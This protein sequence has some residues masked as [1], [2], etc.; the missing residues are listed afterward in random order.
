MPSNKTYLQD[1]IPRFTINKIFVESRNI[2]IQCSMRRPPSFDF[3]SWNGIGSINLIKYLDFHIIAVKGEQIELERNLFYAQNRVSFLGSSQGSTTDWEDSLKT[4]LHGINGHAKINILEVL[5]GDYLGR[6]PLTATEIPNNLG[7]DAASDHNISFQLSIECIEEITDAMPGLDLFAFCQLDLKS[8]NDDFDMQ[9]FV[10]SLTKIGGPLV[11]EKALISKEGTLVVPK[12]RKAFALVTGEFYSGPA[13]YH[14]PVEGAPGY[15]GWMTGPSTGDMDGRQR[16]NMREIQ[17]TK[18]SSNIF[19]E[20]SIN[21]EYDGYFAES[22]FFG[23]P[24][25]FAAPYGNLTLG[26]DLLRS[27]LSDTGIM[28]D[29]KPGA[30]FAKTSNLDNRMLRQ[31]TITSEMNQNP[32][33]FDCSLPPEDLFSIV[34]PQDTGHGHY[35]SILLLN[36]EQLVR[37]NSKFGYLLDF[38]REELG[39]INRVKAEQSRDFIN[40]V[41]QYSLIWQ[42]RVFRKRITNNPTGNNRVVTSEFEN[43]DKDQIEKL[44]ASLNMPSHYTGD[45][46][47]N[48]PGDLATIEIIDDLIETNTGFTKTFALKDHDLFQNYSFGKYQYDVEIEI[49]D[50]IRLYLVILHDAFKQSTANFSKFVKEASQPYLDPSHSRHFIGKQFLES[51]QEV[52]ASG[53]YNFYINDFTTIYKEATSP[54]GRNHGFFQAART[55][56]SHYIK[57]VY[58][59]TKK[60]YQ[61]VHNADQMIRS[62]MPRTGSLDNMN[63]FL[64]ICMRLQARF[65]EM[66]FDLDPDENTSG[67]FGERDQFSHKALTMGSKKKHVSKDLE[68]P[69]RYIRVR[70][71]TN[72]RVDAASKFKVLFSADN[73]ASADSEHPSILSLPPGSTITLPSEFFVLNIG[74]IIGSVD[75]QPNRASLNLSPAPIFTKT[76]IASVNHSNNTRDKFFTSAKI[77]ASIESVK[78]KKGL[79]NSKCANSEIGLEDFDNLLYGSAG[80]TFGSLLSKVTNPTP[81]QD[82][83]KKLKGEVLQSSLQA[84]IFNSIITAEDGRQFEDQMEEKFKD[85]FVTKKAAGSLYNTVLFNMSAK[86]LNDRARNKITYRSRV[87]N[88]DTSQQTKAKNILKFNSDTVFESTIVTEHRLD[89]SGG[90]GDTTAKRATSTSIIIKKVAANSAPGSELVNSITIESRSA[91]EGPRRLSISRKSGEARATGLPNL[92]RT[93]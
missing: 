55:L 4:G 53:N 9:N 3:S 69:D 34:P 31:L 65:R 1:V 73:A 19:M 57:L 39:A 83:E 16:L 84:S 48:Q 72:S 22:G 37:T 27:I 13:H 15:T 67:I 68:Y 59:L 87:E 78:T 46:Q 79:D 93:Y 77:R 74:S 49:E 12:T 66:I 30:R 61:G 5:Q 56:V 91:Q 32:N 17:N 10:G 54:G 63:F 70:S 36:F 23:N 11:Y 47:T 24:N 50:G 75:L 64:D 20:R 21:F 92:S 7:L 2:N 76:V 42:M 43:Y 18:V 33:L 80:T 38:H 81:V 41:L 60:S 14:R 51:E 28:L 44:I 45:S 29:A 85:I 88:C 86:K 58:I 8:L 6:D 25:R 26:P 52:T 90:L 71:K 35:M 62:L 40:N 82:I 89:A